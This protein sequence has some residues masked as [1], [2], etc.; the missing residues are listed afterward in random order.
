MIPIMFKVGVISGMIMGV[1]AMILNK[2]KFTSL[3]LIRYFGGLLTG[4]AS[5]SVNFVSGFVFHLVVA[6]CLGLVYEFLIGRLHV[7]RELHIA[8]FFGFVH[9][10]ISGSSLPLFDKINPCVAQ[11]LIKPMKY[12][13][14][15]YGITAV[16]TFIACHVLYA[17]CVFI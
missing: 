3:D 15:G 1:V 10:F 9:A 4:K 7:S 6:G 5:G 12:F 14:S 13:A 17:I 2:I 8:V 16:I 11:G